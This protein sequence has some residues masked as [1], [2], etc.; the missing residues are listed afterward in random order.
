MDKYALLAIDRAVELAKEN[1]LKYRRSDFSMSMDNSKMVLNKVYNYDDTI[2]VTLCYDFDRCGKALKKIRYNFLKY[3]NCVVTDYYVCFTFKKNELISIK[4]TDSDRLET[5]IRRIQKLLA[6][7]DKERNQSKAEAISASMKAQKLLAEYH[8]DI[9]DVMGGDRNKTED[10]KELQIDIATGKK[11][12]YLLAEAVAGNY[13]CKFYVIDRRRFIFVGYESDTIVAR[14]IF[15]YLFT[16]GN[17]LANKYVKL[18]KES[19]IYDIKGLYNSFCVGFVEGVKKELDKNSKAL[20]LTASLDVQNRYNQL[21]EGATLVDTSMSIN[22]KTA[23]N[24]GFVE[25]K[26]ALNSRYLE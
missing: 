17:K 20:M 12:K 18:Q 21:V 4:N 25:G 11:W 10:I 2:L 5:V 16:V 9:V 8:L 19:G 7:G 14:Q 13:C 15:F 22:N 23:Y 3:S 1:G 26:R 24:N 6:L